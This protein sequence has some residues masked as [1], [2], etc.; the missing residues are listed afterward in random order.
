MP[1]PLSDIETL[2]ALKCCLETIE[3]QINDLQ[4]MIDNS[5]EL[6]GDGFRL[7]SMPKWTRDKGYEEPEHIL[8][9]DED[10]LPIFKLVMG[11]LK[12]KKKKVMD[13]LKKQG[14]GE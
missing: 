2:Y 13:S 10:D 8:Y 3:T 14:Y 11:H 1:K 5:D 7:S 4:K 9:L 12:A 6:G